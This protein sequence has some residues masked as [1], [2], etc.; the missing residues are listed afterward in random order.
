MEGVKK[1]GEMG[2]QRDKVIRESKCAK[3]SVRQKERLET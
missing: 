1:D 2:R 3:G